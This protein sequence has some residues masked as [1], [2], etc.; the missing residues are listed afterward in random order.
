MKTLVVVYSRTGITLSL[1][2]KIARELQADLEIIRDNVNRKGV[3]GFLRSG[4]EAVR[5]KFR[6]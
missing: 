5:K 1:A 3:L 4:Y 6:P 2:K